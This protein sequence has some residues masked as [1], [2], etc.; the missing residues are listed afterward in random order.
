MLT[1]VA[2]CPLPA[3]KAR[4]LLGVSTG[5]TKEQGTTCERRDQDPISRAFEEIP[6]EI[7]RQ[8]RSLSCPMGDPILIERELKLATKHKV[9]GEGIELS[10]VNS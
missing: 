5:T 2:G 1:K 3:E 8:K 4:G 6:T 9:R 10:K 7:P